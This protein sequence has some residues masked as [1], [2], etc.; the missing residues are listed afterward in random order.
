ML[1][2]NTEHCF[3]ILSMATLFLTEYK[4]LQQ[5]LGIA[6]Y[7]ALPRIKSV[8]VNVGVGKNRDN[9]GYID[10]VQ[11]DIKAITGQAPNA[12]HAR[13][14]VAGFSVRQGNLVGFAVTL[15]GKLME[16]FVTR[17]INITLPRVRD[18]RGISVTSFDGRGNLSVGIREQ[19]AFP[20]VH[21]EATDFVFGVE[22]TFVTTAVNNEQGQA[23]MQALGF[24]LTTSQDTKEE[25]DVSQG[26]KAEPAGAKK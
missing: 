10:A 4:Q 23:L 3:I 24:P 22:I 11:K 26:K 15:R 21:P 14:A 7:H 6:N 19:L 2:R 16:D 18:F 8:V 1:G 5:K 25:F 13:R 9:K 17:F 12:R 20:E